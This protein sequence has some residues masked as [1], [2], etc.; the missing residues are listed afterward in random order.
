MTTPQ[1]AV[2]HG[3]V[4]QE[5]LGS[6]LPLTYAG[7]ADLAAHVRDAVGR[8]PVLRGYLPSSR[9]TA[10]PPRA[11]PAYVPTTSWDWWTSASAKLGLG[12]SP[13]RMTM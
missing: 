9:L 13:R 2:P 10:G 1:P 6:P 11:A 12:R 4:T 8:H 5:R 3:V 7:P